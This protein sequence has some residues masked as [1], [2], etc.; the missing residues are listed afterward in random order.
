MSQVILKPRHYVFVW[1]ALVCL[2]WLTATVSRI[3]LGIYNTLVMLL[4]AA[5][6]ASLV[7]MFFMGLLYES[8]KMVWIVAVAGIFWLSLLLGLSMVDYGT[9]GYLNIPGK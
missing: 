7:A 4:I 1:I 2:T 9:R 6:K 8:Y 5:T 3:D